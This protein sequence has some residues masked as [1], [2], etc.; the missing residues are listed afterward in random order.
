[1]NEF[2]WYEYRRG[3]CGWVMCHSS[4]PCFWCGG[5]TNSL[6]VNFQTW[7]HQGVCTMLAERDYWHACTA[8]ELADL[9]EGITP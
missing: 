6:D 2:I 5:P 4:G 8:A 9:Q 3:G 7:L 1:M